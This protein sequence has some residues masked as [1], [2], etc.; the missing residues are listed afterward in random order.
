MSILTQNPP[1]CYNGAMQRKGLSPVELLLV[2][3]A[4]GALAL[5]I[6]Y[7]FTMTPANAPSGT[8]SPTPTVS[9]SPSPTSSPTASSTPDA[10]G[11]HCGGFIA[12]A[13]TC[14]DGYQCLLGVGGGHNPDT[15]GVC[16][17][18]TASSSNAGPTGQ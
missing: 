11:M 12:N 2:I 13:P 10:T 3:M 18:I 8:P 7:W 16:E 14:P 9:S 5:V 1:A 4:I 15:G 6:I 17:P